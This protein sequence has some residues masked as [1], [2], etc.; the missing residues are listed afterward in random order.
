MKVWIVMSTQSCRCDRWPMA[1][2]TDLDRAA[3]YAHLHQGEVY[4]DPFEVKEGPK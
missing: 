1:I 2:F 3:E 4:D